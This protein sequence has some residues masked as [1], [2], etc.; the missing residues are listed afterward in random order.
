[1]DWVDLLFIG[2][3][4]VIVCGVLYLLLKGTTRS[5]RQRQAL[6]WL[7]PGLV[8]LLIRLIFT[9]PTTLD[10]ALLFG[11]IIIIIASGVEI[12]RSEK[13]HPRSGL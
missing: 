3:N 9:L 4:I 12:I 13:E 11:A 7:L 1:M 10:T 8:A 6:W 2:T 5:A